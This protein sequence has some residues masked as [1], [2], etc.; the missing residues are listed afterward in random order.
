ME[1]NVFEKVKASVINKIYIPKRSRNIVKLIIKNGELKMI[2]TK[3]QNPKGLHGKYHITKADGSPVKPEAEYFV[4]RLD[5][6]GDFP[7]VEAG[8]KAIK[9]YADEIEEY[10]PKLAKD[11]RERYELDKV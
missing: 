8:R 10:I 5:K 4:L 2:P 1:Y 11:L 3:E 7:H 9:V 6:F